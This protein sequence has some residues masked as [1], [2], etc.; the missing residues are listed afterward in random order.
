MVEQPKFYYKVVP[1]KLEKVVD[2]KGFHMRKARYYVS[3]TKKAGFK[4]HPAFIHD[5]KEKNFI[6]LSAY[7]G[8]VFDV[9]AGQYI[10]NDAQTTVLLQLLVIN[11]IHCY[12]KKAEWIDPG[13]TRN[14]SRV[15]QRIVVQV[16]FNLM[17][18]QLQHHSVILTN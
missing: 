12:T 15:V 6:Y 16:G 3:D 5:G 1:L 7:E 9:S 13:L 14:G 10:L 11:V 2:G 17:Q 18:L 8:S 4:L